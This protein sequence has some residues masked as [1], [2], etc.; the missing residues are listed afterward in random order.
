MPDET[1]TRCGE[2]IP[3][4]VLKNHMNICN[5][6]SDISK[7]QNNSKYCGELKVLGDNQELGQ[8]KDMDQKKE[9]GLEN[10]EEINKH[11]NNDVENPSTIDSEYDVTLHEASLASFSSSSASEIEMYSEIDSE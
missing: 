11:Q 6:E 3:A 5:G 2:D 1:C 7:C 9:K 10:K 8:E 4:R